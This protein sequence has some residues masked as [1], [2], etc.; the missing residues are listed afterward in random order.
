MYGNDFIKQHSEKF[1]VW[2]Y[3]NADCSLKNILIVLFIIIFGALSF[4]IR[5]LY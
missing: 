2:N 3:Q 4:P 5:W 1:M